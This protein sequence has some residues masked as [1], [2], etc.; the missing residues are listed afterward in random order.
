MFLFQVSFK[1][2]LLKREIKK[3]F[4]SSIILEKILF[5]NISGAINS[6]NVINS[7]NISEILILFENFRIDIFTSAFL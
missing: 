6:N 7:N 1:L 5:Y 3:Y 2:V 4:S